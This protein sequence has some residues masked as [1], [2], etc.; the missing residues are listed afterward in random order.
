MTIQAI[1]FDHDG[2]LVDSEP[3]HHK[4]WAEVVSHFDV[5][6]EQQ[7]YKENYAGLPC[8]ATAV[9]MVLHFNLTIDPLLLAER[10][11]SKTREYL[12]QAAFPLMPGAIETLDYFYDAGLKLAVVTG[13]SREGINATLKFYQLDKYFSTIVSK[14][15]VKTSK[16]APDCYQL[17]LKNLGLDVHQA[18]ALEDTEHG[19]ISAVAAEL[20]CLAIPNE[21]SLSHDF[22]AANE[23]VGDMLAAKSWII[24][25][26]LS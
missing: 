7:F 20:I 25:N 6:L 24:A 23:T 8:E 14:D 21:M 2:T 11:N 3:E 26:H 18:I 10:K 16:P 22:G 12:S 17:A 9:N 13:A 1:L 19:V 15:D 4:H 5:A